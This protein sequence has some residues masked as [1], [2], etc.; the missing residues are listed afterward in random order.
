MKLKQRFWKIARWFIVLFFFMF[1]CRLIYGYVATDI[2]A[3]SDNAGDF[4][5][6]VENLRKNYASE[7][8]VSRQASFAASQ[9]YEKTATVRTKT[10]QF[11]KDLNEIK[12][13]TKSF[14]GIIQ[15]EQNTGNKGN[16]EI[17]LLIGVNPEKFDSFYLKVQNI[18]RINST[19]ITKIDKTNEY[20]EL[21]AKKASL[22]KTLLSLN[23]LRS[24]SGVISDYVSLHD[25]IL[26]IETKLQELG[27]ELGN[28]DAENEFCSIRFSLFEGAP[29]KGISFLS[30]LKTT[31]EWTIRYYAIL[32]VSL[33]CISLSVFII[34][35][36]IDKLKIL[37][38]LTKTS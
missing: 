11:E 37:S 10:S 28:F 23:E 35:L 12:N 29:K 22:E 34:L 38:T 9:K 19:E 24:R 4:F 33:V 18:G 17:H 30:R 1:I 27:V 26:E 25:K 2:I 14:D 5:S 21:N 31:T 20:R 15:Y 16:R 6:S 36:I 8:N 32:A 13:K 7:N 3:S